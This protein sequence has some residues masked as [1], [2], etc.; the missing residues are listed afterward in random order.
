[1]RNFWL[2]LSATKRCNAMT[3]GGL[4]RITPNLFYVFMKPK[5]KSVFLME[6]IVRV[7][8]EK[9]DCE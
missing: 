6:A 2:S 3:F 5:Y 4:H 9:K 7:F 1:M 8:P